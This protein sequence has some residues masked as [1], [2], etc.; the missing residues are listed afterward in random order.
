[1]K[2]RRPRRE[3]LAGMGAL[4]ATAAVP[5]A[6]LAGRERLYP[7][8]DLSYFDTPIPPA[9]FE[10]HIGYASITWGGN[11]RQ[12]IEDISSLKY[13]GIQ[14]RS[15]AVQEF[16]TG[17]ALRDVLEKNHLKMV[18]LSS[19]NV[20]IDPAVESSELARH[21]ANAKFLHDAGGLYLQIIDERPKGREITAADYKRLGQL[22]TTLGKRVTDLG[23]QLGYHNHM[24][25]M[26]QTPDGLEQIMAA[27]DP[28]YARLEL[29][30]AHFFQGGG[31]PAEAVRKYREQL[32]FLHLKDV[33][34]LPPGADAKRS[35]RFVE[36][37]RGLVNLPD[38][39]DALRKIDFRGWGIVELDAVP[40]KGGTPKE[41][42]V[43]NKEYV[44]EKLGLKV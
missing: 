10:L 29:D 31:D 19:G 23:V 35:Y 22:L 27:C 15:N 28:R 11:D 21:V 5:P 9:P 6:L 20:N 14:V 44:Q 26:G 16:G 12:A 38:V 33:E 30:V 7:P 41:S 3:F 17:S 34:H 1:M 24:G 37:G 36:L 39:L 32:L 25:A 40:E 18:A 2:F 13:P 8:R 42:A 4:A 43:I